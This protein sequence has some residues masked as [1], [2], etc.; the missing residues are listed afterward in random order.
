MRDLLCHLRSPLLNYFFLL[1]GRSMNLEQFVD[2]EDSS[3]VSSRK[4]QKKEAFVGSIWSTLWIG[5]GFARLNDIIALQIRTLRML[6]PNWDTACVFPSSFHLSSS[7]LSPHLLT[8]SSLVSVYLVSAC[9]LLFVRSLLL[10]GISVY[11][12]CLLRVPCSPVF[13]WYVFFGYWFPIPEFVLL[14]CLFTSVSN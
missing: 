10:S 7:L 2:T 4:R 14:P 9:P 13:L 1:F 6:L 8:V 3:S 11:S 12:A 5:T